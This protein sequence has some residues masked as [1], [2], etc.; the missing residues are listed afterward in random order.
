M[1]KQ[2]VNGSPVIPSGQIQIG[3][4]LSTLQTAPVPH[5]PGH[6]S[7]HFS[8]IHAK[9]LGHS[10]LIV[11]S[12]RQFGG[13]PRYPTW[14]EHDGDP[15]ISLHCEYKP[16]GDG[17]HGLTG[18]AGRAGGNGAVKSKINKYQEYI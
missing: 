1:G 7:L 13:C 16:H 6:G 10:E 15:P 11:H 5:E 8:R 14:H 2:F 9:L 12:G 4:W 18:T 17:T 3:V